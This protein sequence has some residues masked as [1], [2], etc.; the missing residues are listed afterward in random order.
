[1]FVV[2]VVVF[3]L[4]THGADLFKILALYF[5]PIEGKTNLWKPAGLC[6]RALYDACMCCCLVHLIDICFD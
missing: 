4:V 5:Q 1:M 3:N 2:V 6:L